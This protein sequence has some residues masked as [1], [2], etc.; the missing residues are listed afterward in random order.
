MASSQVPNFSAL[1][2][3]IES[4]TPFRAEVLARQLASQWELSRAANLAA[5]G[6]KFASQASELQRLVETA[7][8]EQGS[9]HEILARDV[10]RFRAQ[11]Y[12]FQEIVEAA[13]AGVEKLRTYVVPE[14]EALRAQQS[15]FQKLVDSVAIEMQ[16]LRELTTAGM[17]RIPTETHQQPE[18]RPA[19]P[20][21][22]TASATAADSPKKRE[23]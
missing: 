10:E 16:R 7:L 12:Q 21:Q 15:E 8:K 1:L 4:A 13:A 22:E 14:V 18:V 17:A 11:Q 19:R 3:E 2:D 5:E 20:S 6:V 9:L 23:S